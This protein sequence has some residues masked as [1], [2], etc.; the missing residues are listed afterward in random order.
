MKPKKSLGG[1]GRVVHLIAEVHTKGFLNT[2]IKSVHEGQ[3]FQCQHCE[4]KYTQKSHLK[5]HIQSI[6]GQNLVQNVV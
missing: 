1:L 4:Q 6:H 2:H 3:T 5:T